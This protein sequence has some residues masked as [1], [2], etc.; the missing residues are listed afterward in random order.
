MEDNKNLNDEIT[1]DVENIDEKS[2][3]HAKDL[4]IFILIVFVL[5]IAC[6]ITLLIL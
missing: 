6:F 5:V 1:N 2:K 4:L 3:K